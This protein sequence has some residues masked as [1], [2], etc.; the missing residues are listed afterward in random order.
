MADKNQVELEKTDKL[1]IYYRTYFCERCGHVEVP[2]EISGKPGQKFEFCPEC[3]AEH[4]FGIRLGRFVYKVGRNWRFKKVYTLT[5]FVP[6]M[7]GSE[8]RAR[9]KK[10]K[11][12]KK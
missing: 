7:T 9:Q 3:G 10:I 12:A 1:S 6:G 2:E 4:L 5:K 8:Q 11:K